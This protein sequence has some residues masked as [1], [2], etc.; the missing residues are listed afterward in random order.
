MG[1]N[2]YGIELVKEANEKRRYIE[3]VFETHRLNLA[4]VD[5]LDDL[6]AWGCPP[7]VTDKYALMVVDIKA[8]EKDL[9]DA[10]PVSNDTKEVVTEFL[11]D[12]VD[13]EASDERE[14]RKRIH[15]AK[16]VRAFRES[17][18]GIAESGDSP[19]DA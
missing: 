3:F 7:E 19:E 12:I 6:I 5:I 1:E 14:E 8:A 11:E 17:Y 18:S 9:L 16:S 13:K 4:L 10:L 15:Q 2:K